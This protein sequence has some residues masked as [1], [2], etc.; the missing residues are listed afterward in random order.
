MKTLERQVS[1]MGRSSGREVKS[2]GYEVCEACQEIWHNGSNCPSNGGNNEEE[3]N[4]VYSSNRKPHDMNS[5]TYHPGLRNH[6]KFSYANPTNQLN[7]NFQVPN[8]GAQNQ[9]QRGYQN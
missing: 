7:P 2:I 5:N 6:P 3:I 1:K 8:Q 4:Q 9:Q